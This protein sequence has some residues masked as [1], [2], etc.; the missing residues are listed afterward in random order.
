MVVS[1]GMTL[2]PGNIDIFGG[3]SGVNTFNGDLHGAVDG[4]DGVTFP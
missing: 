3:A 4:T 2:S 1:S